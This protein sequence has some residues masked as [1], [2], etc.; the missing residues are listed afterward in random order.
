MNAVHQ[1]HYQRSLLDRQ[2]SA[3]H[4]GAQGVVIRACTQNWHQHVSE[5]IIRLATQKY[6]RAGLEDDSAHLH[7]RSYHPLCTTKCTQSDS[8]IPSNGLAA[9]FLRS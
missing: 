7:T 3:A 2:C 9:D 5:A 6:A 8:E 1:L 4:E